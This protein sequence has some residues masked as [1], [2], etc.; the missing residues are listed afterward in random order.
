MTSK[1]KKKESQ[2]QEGADCSVTP[3]SELLEYFKYQDRIRQEE[4]E[5]REQIRKQE[6]E[7]R[8]RRWQAEREAMQQQFLMLMRQAEA[9]DQ[10][11]QEER[12]QM[13]ERQQN[14]T[15]LEE[16][17]R[18]VRQL[19][20]ETPQLAKMT[21]TTDIEEYLEMFESHMTRLEY[22]QRTWSGQLQPLLNDECRSVVLHLKPDQRD[23]YKKVKEELLES[24]SICCS[25]ALVR[26]Q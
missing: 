5:E 18:R 12:H 22:P 16:Q 26:T 21:K 6:S 23:S 7:E 15:K 2:T 1:G 8:D 3:S 10:A 11:Y 24:C 19:R 4:R 9:R 13:D 17:D 25:F 14:Q 20:K